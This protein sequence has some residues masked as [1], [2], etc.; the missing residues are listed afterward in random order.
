MRRF[1]N[2]LV[3]LAVAAL[4]AAG[5]ASASPAK[6][7]PFTASYAGQAS[8]KVT[9]NVAAISAT[10]T[11]KATTIGAGKVTGAGTGDSSQQPC[12][13]FGGIGS[14]TGAKGTV[15][16]KLTTGASGCGDEGG[17]VFTVKG[18]ATVL[19]TTGALLKARGTLKFTGLYNHDD[20][21]FSLKFTGTL[22]K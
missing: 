17:H 18:Y 14:I 11:G 16:Y 10:G 6:L 7:V 4:A 13:P 3:T 2:T 19:K 1:T 9:G 20:G 12:V 22:K 15:T 21:T 8:V 5:A